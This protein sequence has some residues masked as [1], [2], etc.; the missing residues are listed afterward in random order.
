MIS[1]F[2]QLLV[3]DLVKLDLPASFNET[4]AISTVAGLLDGHPDLIGDPA[5][6]RNAVL[7]RE[8]LSPTALGHGVAFPHAR[9]PQ[10]K[11][12]VLAVG[13]SREG[14]LFEQ[15]GQRVHLLF[16]IGTPFNKVPEY[17][18]VVG[19]LVRL[20]KSD[21]V[22]ENML[23]AATVEEFLAPLRAGV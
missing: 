9:T 6:F 18:A 12:I 8:K 22:R 10:V 21:V 7:E 23:S 4:E 11:Q 17:L 15:A 20:L 2:S 16:V 14:V 13:R 5:D 3:P 1:P 19:R